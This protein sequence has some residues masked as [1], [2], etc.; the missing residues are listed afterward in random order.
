MLKLIKKMIGKTYIV[1]KDFVCR[2]SETV[3]LFF[4]FLK[5]KAFSI[6]SALSSCLNRK[7]MNINYAYQIIFKDYDLIN[8]E[9]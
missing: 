1:R 6:Y 2:A 8:Y 7:R 5:D 4:F 3:Y 9:L